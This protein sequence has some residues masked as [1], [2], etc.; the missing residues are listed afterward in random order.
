MSWLRQKSQI[1]NHCTHRRI[2]LRSDWM[3]TSQC[4]NNSQILED[5]CQGSWE[6]PR[7]LL[8]LPDGCNNQYF[9]E[10][11]KF[12]ILIYKCDGLLFCRYVRYYVVTN[13]SRTLQQ[14]GVCL[15][16]ITVSIF[17]ENS[18]RCQH[19][20]LTLNYQGGTEKTGTL[21]SLVLQDLYGRTS[22]KT[23]QP[24]F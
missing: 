18:F 2:S 22:S 9:E 14:Y 5:N 4:H 19:R 11:L 8:V 24:S 3:R 17:S 16:R 1:C 6:S 20:Q 23:M 7:V 10:C 13:K 15:R 12:K 21:F